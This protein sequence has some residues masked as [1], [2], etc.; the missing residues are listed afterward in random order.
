MNVIIPPKRHDGGT[1]FMKLVSY[2]SL[3]EEKKADDVITPDALNK[4]SSRSRPA[5]FDRLV[6]YVE[7]Q[8]VG[9]EFC[10]KETFDDGRQRVICGG[11]EC[12]TNC[13]SL[14]TAA[15]EMNM[16]AAQS[17][18]CQ[19]PVYHFILSWQ[20]GESPT[21]S[22]VFDS[23][24]YCLDELGMT[25]H[26]FVTAIHRDTDNLHCH[27]AVNRVNPM[28]HRAVAIWKDA[29]TLQKCCRVLERRYGFRPDNGSWVWG[30]DNTLR[31]APFH[32]RPAPQGA[33]KRQIFSDKESLYH[34]AVRHTRDALSKAFESGETDWRQLHLLMHEKGLGLRPHHGG[35]VVYNYVQPDGP[36][37]KASDVHPT[38]TRT[39]LEPHYGAFE[40]PP[41]F[42]TDDPEDGVYGIYDTYHPDLQVRDKEARRERREAR[43]DAREALKQRYQD[44]RAGWV[45]P[46]LNVKSRY[47][48]IAAHCQAMKAAV[49]ERYRDP[50]MRK[51]MYRVAEFERMKAM[52]A[53]RITLRKERQV[54]S[55]SGQYRPLPYRRW[56]EGEALHGDAAAISQLRGWAYREKRNARQSAPDMHKD[57]LIVFDVADDAPA[58]S[59]ST[60]ETRLHRDGTIEYLRDGIVGVVDSGERLEIKPG[61]E[62][63][64]DAPNYRL[65]AVIAGRKS[66]EHVQVVGDYGFVDQVLLE[67]CRV[68]Y[69][70]DQEV[71]MPTGDYQK[72]RYAFMEREYVRP[73]LGYDD[74]PV[75]RSTEARDDDA[76]APNPYWGPR[77]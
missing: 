43:A 2:V 31:R 56:V 68:N 70:Q 42:E 57:H 23:A 17:R 50:L 47:Q 60:H 19:N 58:L 32:Y 65:A 74:R 76:P 39:H 21:P 18:R 63:Y 15:A 54:L 13:F 22:Q 77:P 11:V 59:P 26:Q 20:E 14:E 12:E 49:R 64:D 24:R 10:V 16:V 35:L 8:G 53:L 6:S 48:Q 38:L 40:G 71:F 52:A 41:P 51:L 45:K 33:A 75:Y 28:T 55:D 73:E 3:R 44:Y 62:D 9:K 29:D 37:V 69:Q 4:T 7:R 34:Y 67:G 5:V 61:F 25:H 72:A 36:I 27:V 66:G 30:H 1:S 46:D